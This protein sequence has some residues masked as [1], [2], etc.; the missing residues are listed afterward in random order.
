MLQQIRT[1]RKILSFTVNLQYLPA[2]WREDHHGFLI[3]QNNYAFEN[4][5]Y[6]CWYL[7]ITAF[8]NRYLEN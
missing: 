6:L 8:T 4:A 3:K 7:I 1:N 2:N 5:E